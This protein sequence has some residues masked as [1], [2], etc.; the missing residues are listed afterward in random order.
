MEA[1]PFNDYVFFARFFRFHPTIS[2]EED[3]VGPTLVLLTC[4]YR[5]QEFVRVGYFIN[6]DY[7]EPELR[8]TP[9]E[10]PQFDKLIRNILGTKP[11]IKRFPIDWGEAIKPN[12]VQLPDS[13]EMTDSDIDMEAESNEPQD[14]PFGVCPEA[15]ANQI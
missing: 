3:A 2:V 14:I 13:T 15:I 9:P 11:R 1:R 6:N 12:A 5:D 10:H 8:E 4:S 7:A